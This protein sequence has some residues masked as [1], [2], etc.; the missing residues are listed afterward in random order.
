MPRPRQ[1]RGR[2]TGGA[3]EIQEFLSLIRESA[4]D[5]GWVLTYEGEP[6]RFGDHGPIHSI[7]FGFTEA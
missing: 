6:E 2:F 4:K 7:T 3:D 1:V 5:R